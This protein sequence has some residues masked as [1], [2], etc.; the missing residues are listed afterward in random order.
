MSTQSV[1]SN[2][3]DAVVAALGGK[4]AG[5]YRCRFKPFAVT[6]LPAMNVIPEDD[7][8][9]YQN[10]GDIERRMRFHVRYTASATDGVDKVVDAQY[11]SGT[12]LLMADRTLG[13][14]CKILRE[15]AGKWDREQA[16]TQLIALDVTYEAEFST[17]T[18]DPSQPGY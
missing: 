7:D 5:A 1:A 2:I 11:V 16:E 17:T 9:Q 12:K 10:T 4:A 18:T 8:P 3:L 13:N 15:V 14:T 6:E